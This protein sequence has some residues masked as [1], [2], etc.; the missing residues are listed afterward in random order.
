[1]NAD[2]FFFGLIMYFITLGLLIVCFIWGSFVYNIIGESAELSV[3]V[4]FETKLRSNDSSR[5]VEVV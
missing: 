2:C 4:V 1:M 3:R 5:S